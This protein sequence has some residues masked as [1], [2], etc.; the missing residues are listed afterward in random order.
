MNSLSDVGAFTQ[1]YELQANSPAINGGEAIEPNNYYSIQDVTG[2]ARNEVSDIGAYEYKQSTNLVD[3]YW[4]NAF[5][6]KIY[7]GNSESKE[8]QEI[9]SNQGTG[10]SPVDI[11][12]D[13]V[14]NRIFWVE[15]DSTNAGVGSYGGLYS[16]CLL[17]TS[18]S[19]RDG[20][21]SRMPSSA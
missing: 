12:V 15:T 14:N 11:E 3:L 21:L 20:L 2:A 18:P 10:T 8:Y 13:V 17:Y 16:A 5:T 1:V 4:T 7:R 19:P 6:D 9:A